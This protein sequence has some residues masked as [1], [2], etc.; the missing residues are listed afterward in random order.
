MLPG[1]RGVATSKKGEGDDRQ[2][3][4]VQEGG[5]GASEIRERRQPALF[6]REGVL[7]TS[8]QGGGGGQPYLRGSNSCREREGEDV[9]VKGG[10]RNEES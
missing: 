8:S 9:C 2:E 10:R 6:F 7:A 5:E 3:D 4:P 1:G